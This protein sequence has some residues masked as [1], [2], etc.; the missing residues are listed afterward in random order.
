MRYSLAYI[1]FFSGYSVT[2]TF[3]FQS[4]EGK[5]LTTEPTHTYFKTAHLPYAIFTFQLKIKLTY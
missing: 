2:Y 1:H 3:F 5:H 4:M